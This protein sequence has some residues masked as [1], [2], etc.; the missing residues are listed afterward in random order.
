[1]TVTLAGATRATCACS[2]RSISAG[3]WFGTSRQLTFAIA[4]AGS[5]VFAPSPV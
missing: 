3:S 4:R 2:N 1:M 5:T